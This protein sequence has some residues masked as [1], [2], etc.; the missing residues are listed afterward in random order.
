MTLIVS[1]IVGEMVR[2]WSECPDVDCAE[3]IE[4]FGYIV[5]E[6]LSYIPDNHGVLSSAPSDAVGSGEVYLRTSAQSQ[7]VS[8][9]Y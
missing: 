7:Y 9:L 6:I 1:A 8:S 5:H 3:Y 4:P 2:F